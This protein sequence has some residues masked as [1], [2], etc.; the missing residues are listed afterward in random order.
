MKKFSQNGFTPIAII[1]IIAAILVVGG[2]AWYWQSQKSKGIACIIDAKL[3]PDGSYV[4][5]IP[6]KCDFA[7]CPKQIT[8]QPA[9]APEITII[10]FSSALRNGDI[11]RALKNVSEDA[12]ERLQENLTLL[13]NNS[14]QRLANAI[15]NA[16]KINESENRVVCKGTMILPDGKIVEDEFEL[17]LE[18]G[19]WKLNNL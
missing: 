11:P 5:R 10:E 6:P 12:Q 15:S 16:T 18:N 19:A 13:D 9:T 7:Q 2:G 14:R 1:L 3:C 8:S 17:I 4:A